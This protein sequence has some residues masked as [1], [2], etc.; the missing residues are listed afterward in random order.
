MRVT[1]DDWGLHCCTCVTY[2][3]HS[4]PL[5]SIIPSHH[6]VLSFHLSDG[7]GG[8]DGGDGGSGGGPE[9]CE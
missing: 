1:A 5:C 7:G 3:E 2:F 4:C 9:M 8:G 6:S